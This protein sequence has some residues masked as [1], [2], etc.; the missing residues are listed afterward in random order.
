TGE[1]V[2]TRSI[3]STQTP[4]VA[5]DYLFVVTVEAKMVCLNRADGRVR[6]VAELAQYEDP[7]D[8]EDPIVWSGPALG[9]NRLI[10]VSS[11]GKAVSVSPYTGEIKGQVDIREGSFIPPVIARRTLIILNDEGE[12]IAYR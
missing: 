3:A 7:E 11:H 9:S 5:G 10:A 2:W 6:W 12:M 4:W 8:Q 1:R